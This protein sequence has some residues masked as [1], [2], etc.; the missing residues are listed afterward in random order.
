MIILK[1]A[2][3]IEI[4]AIAGKKLAEVIFLLKKE[5][6]PGL[7]T[8]V[9]DDLAYKLIKERNAE[10]AF[11]NYIPPGGDKPFPASLCV[12]INETIVHGIPSNYI[13]QP[14]DIVKLDIGLKYQGFYVDMAETI[15][16]PP[17]NHREK[18]LIIATKKA[19][20]EAIK[21]A[22]PG[23]T[24]GDIG[25]KIESIAYKYNLS[26]AEK[27]T[28]H[29]IG[30]NLHEDPYILNFGNRGEGIKLQEGMVLAIEPMFVL[31][32]KYLI[33]NVDGS[34]R[35][36]DRSKTAHF[37]HTIAILKKGNLILTK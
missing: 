24:L 12:S 13:L 30:K 8:K 5:I 15:G 34:F 33:E 16:I 20:F 37:E 4:M 25:Y 28:G 17:L 31:G 21:I 11:L 26:I 10:P 1:T 2:E 32:K 35:S 19:L 9:L 3:E 22:K 29:G 36:K 23:N 27:L 7:K 14:G 18:E 6:R